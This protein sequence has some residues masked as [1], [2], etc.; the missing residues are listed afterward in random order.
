MMLFMDKLLD[1]IDNGIFLI[2]EEMNIQSMNK[3][4]DI[5]A[6]IDSAS[7]IGKHI[8]DIFKIKTLDLKIIKRYIKSVLLLKTPGFITPMTH[9]DLFQI[10]YI[11]VL[12]TDYKYMQNSIKFVYVDEKTVAVIITDKTSLMCAYRLV[13]HKKKLL[14]TDLENLKMS[15][16]ALEGEKK[17]IEETANYDELT[18]LP[19][20]RF[21]NKWFPSL[22][23]QVEKNNASIAV[24][25]FDLDEFKSVNDNFGH[26][27]G[28]AL[29]ISVADRLKEQVRESDLVV[30]LGGDEFLIIYNDIKKEQLSYVA[31]R[32]ISSIEER[33]LLLQKDSLRVTSSLGIALYPQDGGDLKTLMKNADTALYSA[34]S[35]GKNNFQFF[36]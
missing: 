20:R 19:N 28:D 26:D 35:K 18:M 25:F 22:L 3:W 21:L 24:L 15:H 36:S 8:S 32:I 2:D 29:L 17:D 1:S 6:S 30:R 23:H 16:L 13:E 14:E 11:S 9:G 34:K 12:K 10:P 31:Q 7:C 27:I 4:F 5:H 33:Q